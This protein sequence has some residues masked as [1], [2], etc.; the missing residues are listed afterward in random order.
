MEILRLLG[1]VWDS[2]PQ[3]VSILDPSL[4][5]VA[6][7]ATMRTWY[8]HRTPQEGAKCFE[9]YHGRKYPCPS[10][11]TR[12]ALKAQRATTGIVPYHGPEGEIRGWQKLTVFPLCQDGNIVGIME[13][14]EDVT[15]VEHLKH[16][17]HTLEA[18]VAFLRATLA[19]ERA[20]RIE[21][22]KFF[23]AHVIPLFAALSASLTHDFQ[24][25]LLEILQETLAALLGKESL[26]ETPFLTP[27]EWEV[28]KLLAQGFTSKEIAEMLSVSKKTVDFHRGNIRKKLGRTGIPLNFPHAP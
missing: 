1:G 12:H 17:V 27:R 8:A 7:N 23:A 22:R 13:Y 26:P 10:C 25:T 4:S 2:V 24:R 15:E 21:H 6:M 19:R 9:V 14:V 16:R 3:G 5:I 20:Q 18:E 28:A 11:P